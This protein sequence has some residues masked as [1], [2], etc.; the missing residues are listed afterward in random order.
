MRKQN[1][2]QDK[3]RFNLKEAVE[4]ASAC[5]SVFI[6]KSDIIKILTVGNLILGKFLSSLDQK[7][8][9]LKVPSYLR[10]AL[11]RKTGE[12]AT[13]GAHAK[14]T[15]DNAK[16]VKVFRIAQEL[17]AADIAQIEAKEKEDFK[18]FQD[19]EERAFNLEQDAL[20]INHN[21]EQLKNEVEHYKQ[22]AIAE[23][24]F[25]SDKANKGSAYRI[26][27]YR[28]TNFGRASYIRVPYSKSK[29]LESSIASTGTE[30]KLVNGQYTK[31]FNPKFVE[32]QMSVAE[33]KIQVHAGNVKCPELDILF[34]DNNI[35]VEKWTAE[36]NDEEANERMLTNVLF[37]SLSRESKDAMAKHVPGGMDVINN[38]RDQKKYLSLIDAL[39]DTHDRVDIYKDLSDTEKEAFRRQQEE[40]F[41]AAKLKQYDNES[42]TKYTE[43]MQKRYDLSV[44]LLD[45]I[46]PNWSHSEQ[47]WIRTLVTN[48]N[49]K[50]PNV[51]FYNECFAGRHPC[52]SKQSYK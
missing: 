16:L 50:N 47:T 32:T 51:W 26:V 31:I 42:V 2:I 4:K 52:H 39:L 38:W 46:G 29:A 27:P 49:K 1:K 3:E 15:I 25:R 8:L 44:K 48:V 10:C 30:Y 24:A 6:P 34:N 40:F 21:A 5:I 20:E 19:S 35:A 28:R 7:L 43:R 18:N 14:P 45:L 12:K 11:Y 9:Q 22:Q 36:T 41:S 23:A 33:A 37:E 17:T 13:I